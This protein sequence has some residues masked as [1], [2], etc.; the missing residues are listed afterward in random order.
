MEIKLPAYL[1]LASLE[2]FADAKH[3]ARRFAPRIAQLNN[4]YY[5]V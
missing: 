2:C 1:I 3:S 4:Y 5:R